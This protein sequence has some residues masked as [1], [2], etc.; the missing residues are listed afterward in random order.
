MPRKKSTNKQVKGADKREVVKVEDYGT[1]EKKITYNDGT[2]EIV[3]ASEF[4]K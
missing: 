2:V 4:T 1:E 3:L